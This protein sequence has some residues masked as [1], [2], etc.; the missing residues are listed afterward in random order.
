MILVRGIIITIGT[1]LCCVQGGGHLLKI[2]LEERGRER[3]REEERGRERKREEE[4][5]RERKREEERG[6]DRKRDVD[7]GGKRMG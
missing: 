4:R 2:L 1:I 6:K 7:R 5:G 3:K